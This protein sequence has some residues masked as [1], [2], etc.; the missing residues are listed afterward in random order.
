MSINAREAVDLA[1][2]GGALVINM[3]TVTPDTINAY[4]SGMKAYNAAGNP[5]LFDPVGGG[6]TTL[7][8]D[9]IKTLLTGGFFSVIKGNE[10]EISAVAGTSDVQQ[11]GVDSGPSTS[12][13]ETKVA[14]VKA[15]ARRER[16]IVLMTG[17]TDYLSDG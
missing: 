8:R 14:L 5:V 7:R 10:G 3:G 13:E 2:L 9:T 1:K 12:T 4:L 16:C 11:R 17:A 15:L 6:A